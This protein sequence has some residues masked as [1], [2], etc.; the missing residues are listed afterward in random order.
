MVAGIFLDDCIP[1]DADYADYYEDL[2][3]GLVRAAAEERPDL[4]EKAYREVSARF[5]WG[6]EDGIR[7]ERAL[8][9][10][11]CEL[12]PSISGLLLACGPLP[13]KSIAT[14]P[15]FEGHFMWNVLVDLERQDLIVCDGSFPHDP[16]RLSDKAMEELGISEMPAPLNKSDL[17][18]FHLRECGPLG[19]SILSSLLNLS[20]RETMKIL[21]H[22]MDD[23][24]VVA[25]GRG[26]SRRYRYLGD[27]RDLV[28][29][30]SA[31]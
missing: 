7:R 4:V 23:G 18:A 12:W 10:E 1:Y 13:E 2:D 30:A 31:S 22:H 17:L 19:S 16:L 25:E 21:H 26:R 24:R 9:E 14:H 3:E 27:N 28:A 11:A 8:R 5:D 15:L 6:V 29:D 20:R